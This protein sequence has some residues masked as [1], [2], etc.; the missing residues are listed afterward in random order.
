MRLSILLA[1]QK[2]NTKFWL[3][4][5]PW[6]IFIHT[7]VNALQLVLLCKENDYKTFGQ[8]K[9]FYPLI[10]DLKTLESKGIDIPS[11]G[12][13]K[14]SILFVLG[15]NL[16]SHNIGGSQKILAVRTTFVDIAF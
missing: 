11:L 12:N 14:G 7:T 1:R 8:N 3:C 13:I 16:G 4:I 10:Q 15:D 9:V 2:T 5:L 6:E